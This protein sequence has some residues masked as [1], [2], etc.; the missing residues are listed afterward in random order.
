VVIPEQSSPPLPLQKKASLVA[1]AP[2]NH[3]NQAESLNL[4]EP[5]ATPQGKSKPEICFWREICFR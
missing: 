5:E 2:E 3:K 1:I 4:L